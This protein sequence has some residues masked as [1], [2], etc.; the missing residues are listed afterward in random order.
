VT[1]KKKGADDVAS[2]VSVRPSVPPPPGTPRVAF[3]GLGAMG[4]PMATRVAQF[5]R[6]GTRV[7][8]ELVTWNRTSKRAAPLGKIG[9][10]FAESPRACAEGAEFVFTMVS[11]IEALRAL[12]LGPDGLLAG[13]G[14][15]ATWID[16]STIG[17][18][19]ALE[20]AKLAEAQGAKFVDAPV[21]GSVGPAERGE[22]AFLV[23]GAPRDVQRLEPLF[24]AMAKRV[25]H[26]GEVG[27][28]Q[29]LKVVLNGVG[30]HQVIAFTSM[31]VLGLK[32]GLTRATLVDAFTSGAFGSPAIVG[33]KAK[34]LAK[35]YSPEMTLEHALKDAQLNLDLQKEVGVSLPVQK[36]IHKEMSAAIAQGLGDEDQFG[37]E[38]FFAGAKRS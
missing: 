22:L 12:A 15:R 35:D 24:M 7:K 5:A 25:I 14:K 10:P 23:G 30:A 6:S 27:Q 3:L 4:L 2:P 37:M 8:F 33:K 18:T 29:A 20:M 9:V 13:L 1:S 31:L 11:D 28:G 19:A 17:R 34:V 36:E 32:A 21:S 38:K 26:A 16:M